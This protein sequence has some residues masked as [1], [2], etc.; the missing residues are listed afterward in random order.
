MCPGARYP[1]PPGLAA[2]TSWRAYG[3]TG[4]TSSQPFFQNF[5]T[6]YNML[7]CSFQQGVIDQKNSDFFLGDQGAVAL[8]GGL[9]SEFDCGLHFYLK[10]GY[11]H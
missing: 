11:R 5:S 10:F 4:L 7:L 8:T 3:F 6:N 9:E 2:S 1:W